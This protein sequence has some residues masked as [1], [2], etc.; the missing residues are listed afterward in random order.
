MKT[1][2]EM[3]DSDP[4][5]E[6]NR[7]VKTPHSELEFIVFMHHIRT[8]LAESCSILDAGGGP[9]RY[10]MELCRLGHDV[11]LL[12]ASS[13]CIRLAREK[14]AQELSPEQLRRLK[15][16]V[17][18]DIQDLGRFANG[19]FDAVLCLDPLSCLPD[20]SAR[21]KALAELVRVAKDG[22]LIALGTRGYL[23]ALQTMVRLGGGNLCDHTI[24]EFKLT[25]NCACAGLPHHFFRA[26][27]L[28]TL[29]E[30]HGLQTLLMAGGEGLS[31][32]IPEATNAIAADPEK[33]RI[34]VRTV[35]ETST[36]PAVVDTS[37]HMVYL[38][39]KR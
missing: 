19:T 9:G 20:P 32:A 4:D 1:I 36:E 33:W 35:M 15:E 2:A 25:G 14:A 16:T 17:T 12:D 22:S 10:S 21:H 8:H 6:W 23:A 34:W 28:G 30:Q 27:E 37:S 29:A 3:Y 24:S 18:A 11:V 7:L 39:K 5:Y 13:E 31:S 38:G 26:D